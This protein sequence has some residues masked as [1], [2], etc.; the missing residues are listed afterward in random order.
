MA[1]SELLEN[2]CDEYCK[3]QPS[4]RAHEIAR[5]FCAFAARRLQDRG[6]A[7][8]G[9]N[10]NGMTLRFA[11]GSEYVLLQND[12]D[13]WRVSAVSAQVTGTVE[14]MNARADTA[15]SP[16]FPITGK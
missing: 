14:K 5:A 10:V 7:G 9:Y 15:V 6:I 1:K 13:S 12:S 3:E 2:L 4:E 8:I 11:D 16:S